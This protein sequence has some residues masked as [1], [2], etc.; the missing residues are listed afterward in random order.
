MASTKRITSIRVRRD[1][2]ADGH[3]TQGQLTHPDLLDDPEIDVVLIALRPALNLEWTIRALAKGKHVMLD[4]PAVANS[5]DAYRLFNAPFVQSI[6]APV[7]LEVAPY[8]FH[9]SWLEFERNIERDRI[10]H[11]KITVVVPANFDADK[12]LRFRFEQAGGAKMDLTYALSMMRAI[13]GVDPV[14][15]IRSEVLDP[16]LPPPNDG[17]YRYE[18]VWEFPNGAIGEMTGELRT[19]KTL[20]GLWPTVATDMGVTVVVEHG[21]SVAFN[22]PSRLAPNV[23]MGVTRTVT[24]RYVDGAPSRHSIKIEELGVLQDMVSGRLLRSVTREKTLKAY[25]PLGED[26]DPFSD[27]DREDSDNKNDVVV[28]HDND[29]DNDNA[30]DDSTVLPKPKPYWTAP[31]YQLDAFVKRVRGISPYAPAWVSPEDSQANMRMTKMAYNLAGVP[32]L[33]PSVFHLEDLELTAAQW[34]KFLVLAPPPQQQQRAGGGGPGSAS[35]ATAAQQVAHALRAAYVQRVV[36]EQEA[37][38][39]EEAARDQ[40]KIREQEREQEKMRPGPQA[41]LSR[42][43]WGGEHSRAQW[44]ALAEASRGER[45]ARIRKYVYGQEEEK[46]PVIPSVKKDVLPQAQGVT[47]QVQAATQAQPTQAQPTQAQPTQAQEPP[48]GV[49]R[50]PGT[51]RSGRSKRVGFALTPSQTAPA[52][53]SAQAGGSAHPPQ[54]NNALHGEEEAARPAKTYLPSFAKGSAK[55]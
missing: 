3:E 13:Y 29:N 25:E 30:N 23:Q 35:Q 19:R 31:M 15:C 22:V 9:P 54:D 8:R 33:A 39:E 21:Q 10:A 51:K 53:G 18:L 7:F 34:D 17:P 41:E 16:D 27:N 24:L 28:V 14:K 5:D 6:Y 4:S 11:V 49:L 45:S 55:R 38:W 20:G 40:K 46:E 26:S 48:L 50:S 52:E 43:E 37:A 44:T 42:S 32:L 12:E 2:G 36:E 1:P 47:H